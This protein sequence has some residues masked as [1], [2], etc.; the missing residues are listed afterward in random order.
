MSIQTNAENAKAAFEE[1]RR[2]GLEQAARWLTD[3][4]Q[5][6]SNPQEVQ[7]ADEYRKAI[8]KMKKK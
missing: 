6:S 5:F 3:R 2:R 1:G 7:L 4:C 8:R